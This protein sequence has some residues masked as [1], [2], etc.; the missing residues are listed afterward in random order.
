M[1]DTID[2]AD[3]S[4]SHQ[5]LPFGRRSIDFFDKTTAMH[6]SQARKIIIAAYHQQRQNVKHNK[7]ARRVS[8][9]KARAVYILTQCRR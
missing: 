9:S 4:M 8:S 5:A 7:T 2:G 6:S 1:N 3:D